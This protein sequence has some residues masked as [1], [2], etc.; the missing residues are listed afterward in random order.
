MMN[1]VVG[2]GGILMFFLMGSLFFWI[3]W[4]TWTEKA[5]KW[6]GRRHT[7]EEYPV[8]YYSALISL[9]FGAVCMFGI[10]FV[11]TRIVLLS[12]TT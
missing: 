9:L 6:S 8:M 3:A 7:R 5:Y 2:F 11:F 12:L 4:K 10:T 1:A